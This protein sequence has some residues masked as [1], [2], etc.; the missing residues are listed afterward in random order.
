KMTRFGLNAIVINSDTH[1]EAKKSGRD[2]WVEARTGNTMVLNSPEELTTHGFGQLLDQKAFGDRVCMLGVDEVHLLYWWGNVF[3]PAF[4][5]I[6]NL[7]ACLPIVG[8]RRRV[9]L[10]ATTATLHVGPTMDT[11]S[12]ILGW[13]A[14]CA[15]FTTI[16]STI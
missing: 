8:G 10:M 5:Q 16:F 1:A 13:T 9:P 7:H 4:C 6:G 3:Q 11:V 2:L 12:T 14:S 15:S